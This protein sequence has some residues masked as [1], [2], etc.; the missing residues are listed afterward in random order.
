MSL[1]E[2]P[3]GLRSSAQ[4]LGSSLTSCFK[5]FVIIKFSKFC[6]ENKCCLGS[7]HACRLLYLYIEQSNSSK[8]MCCFSTNALLLWKKT[9]RNLL[10]RQFNWIY[11]ECIQTS[12]F[13]WKEFLITDNGTV[14]VLITENTCLNIQWK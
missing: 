5:Y 9:E 2:R 10:Q 13:S 7:W 14:Y 3:Q 1:V 8:L 11:N 4:I 12:M 6:K